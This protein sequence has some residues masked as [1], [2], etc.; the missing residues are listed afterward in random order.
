[1]I[2]KQHIISSI[3]FLIISGVAFFACYS[4]LGETTLAIHPYMM[5]TLTSGLMTVLCILR[6]IVGLRM[7]PDTPSKAKKRLV[8][9][10]MKSLLTMGLIIVYAVLMK[11]VG[12]IITTFVYMMAQMLILR[13][14]K[15]NWLLMV[16]IS[17][18]MSVGIYFLFTRVFNIM[19]PAGILSFM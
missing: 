1:M 14:G 15:K 4:Q 6:L 17:L 5:P 19:L 8:E 18:V 10:P 11:S 3:I 12:F 2:K 16:I 13:E 7:P 9:V